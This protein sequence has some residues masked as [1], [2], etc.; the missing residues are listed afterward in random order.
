MRLYTTHPRLQKS[1][2]LPCGRKFFLKISRAGLYSPPIKP[3]ATSADAWIIATKL[4]S[5]CY[6][7]ALTA[8]EYWGLTNQK[9]LVPM[10]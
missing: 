2:N 9:F 4:Y 6:I 3:V 8:A 10:Y 1:K 7:G 5:P